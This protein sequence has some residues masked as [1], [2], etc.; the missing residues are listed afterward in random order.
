MFYILIIAWDPVYDL[1][2]LGVWFKQRF[3]ASTQQ[4]NEEN[5]SPASRSVTR[6]AICNFVS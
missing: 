2:F 6:L 3:T 1:I 5:D 4:E